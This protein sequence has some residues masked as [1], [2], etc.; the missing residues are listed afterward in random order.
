MKALIFDSSTII[1]MIMN[2]LADLLRALKKNFDGKFLITEQVRYET[3]ERPHQ[4]KEYELGALQI[5]ELLDE[6]VL[7]LPES[8]GID[9]KEVKRKTE[10]ILNAANNIFSARNRFMHIIDAGEASC[11]ALSIFAEEKG[12]K[13]LIVIDERTTRMLAEKPEN[14]YKLFEKKLHTKIRMFKE[15]MPQINKLKFIRSTELVYVAWKKQLVKINEN[16]EKVLDALLYA[17]KFKGASIS[18]EEIDEIKSLS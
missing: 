5:F 16:K 9:S 8:I 12:V 18:R 7:E 15:N 2:G 11:I 10:E 4:I 13:N 1:N 3:I 17:T 14:L 6:K